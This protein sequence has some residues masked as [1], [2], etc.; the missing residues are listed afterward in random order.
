[1]ALVWDFTREIASGSPGNTTSYYD[2][3]TQAFYTNSGYIV[4]QIGL[5]DDGQ[6]QDLDRDDAEI[7]SETGYSILDIEHQHNGAVYGCAQHDSNVVFFI[8]N[9]MLDV[10]DLVSDGSWE[11]QPDNPIKAGS[12]T[13][14]N[15]NNELFQDSINSIFM[16]GNKVDLA[17][18]VGNL[19]HYDLGVFFIESS[20]FAMP[21]SEF[22]FSGRNKIG[23]Y[24][25]AQNF[26]ENTAVT[27]TFTAIFASIMVLAGLRSED[28][29]I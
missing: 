6:W 9:Y 23:F 27:G 25:S 19:N 13:L 22:Q 11:L 29:L 24:F 3:W 17:I 10:S 18:Q 5:L 20:P 16:P 4:S 8:Y 14:M 26:D 28:Y 2:E 21:A 12:V 7:I 15:V 1:M